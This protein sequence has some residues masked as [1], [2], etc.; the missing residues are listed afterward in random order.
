MSR[1]GKSFLGKFIFSGKVLKSSDEDKILFFYISAEQK[2]FF[3]K[4]F[5]GGEKNKLFFELCNE[6][7]LYFAEIYFIFALAEKLFR[8]IYFFSPKA[9][10]FEKSEKNTF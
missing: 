3:L 7:K 9:K 10:I 2:Y 5:P 4:I 6:I 8:N 1:K